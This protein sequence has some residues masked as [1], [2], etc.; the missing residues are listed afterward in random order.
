LEIFPLDKP[1]TS[2][3]IFETIFHTFRLFYKTAGG[4][5]IFFLI[6]YPLHTWLG[7]DAVPASC[8]TVMGFLF[9]AWILFDEVHLD[10][11]N[12]IHRKLDELFHQYDDAAQARAREIV[13][14]IALI[15]R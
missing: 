15:R 10:R 1:T 11:V 13:H 3:R 4:A 14:Q 2:E 9:A 7:L 5:S 6:Y 8:A 12:S